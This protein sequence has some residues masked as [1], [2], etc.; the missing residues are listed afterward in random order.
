M[1][2][3]F[4]HT[5]AASVMLAAMAGI[6]SCAEVDT[7]VMPDGPNIGAELD[8]VIVTPQEANPKFI[9]DWEH[10]Y[11]LNLFTTGSPHESSAVTLPWALGATT[12]LPDAIRFDVKKEDGWEMGFLTAGGSLYTGCNYFSL[13]NR[14]NGTLRVFHY[15]D[16]ALGSGS[17]FAYEMDFNPAAST[18]KDQYPFY[19]VQNYA[20]PSC[21]AYDDLAND[22]DLINSGKD[23]LWKSFLTPYS[24]ASS[25]AMSRGWYCF[26][27]DMTAYNP[28]PYQDWLSGE[29]TNTKFGI[30]VRNQNNADVSLTGS[31]SANI[32]GTFFPSGASSN[33]GLSIAGSVLGSMGGLWNNPVTQQLFGLFGSAI[34]G[35]AR[36]KIKGPDTGTNGPNPGT[37]PTAVSNSSMK[38]SLWGGAA[39]TIAGTALNALNQA[40]DEYLQNNPDIPFATR[41]NDTGCIIS[42]NTEGPANKGKHNAVVKPHAHSINPI[43]WVTDDTYVPAS[44]N[45]GSLTSLEEG[46]VEPG[47]AD[48]QLDLERGVVVVSAEA[49]KPFAIPAVM[50]DLFG[51]ESYHGQDYGFFYGDIRRNA[52]MRIAAFYSNLQGGLDPDFTWPPKK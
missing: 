19:H 17:T 4:I 1:R 11:T 45:L 15:V 38:L 14:H 47:I 25:T 48:A 42:W 10:Q 31:I 39:M 37:F 52:E 29:T 28:N 22:A 43:Y 46:L 34:A 23:N 3:N 21:Y 7:P 50:Q 49:A 9:E 26:D 35:K 2:K 16:E 12:S 24:D 20:I 41:A 8:T 51:P 33:K 44:E 30:Y 36:M 27:V 32:N 18:K 5:L 6:I 13:Y 40:T